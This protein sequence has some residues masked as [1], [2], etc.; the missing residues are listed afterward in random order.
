LS[1]E[2][3]RLKADGKIVALDETIDGLSSNCSYSQSVLLSSWANSSLH[4]LLRLPYSHMP[5]RTDVSITRTTSIPIKKFNDD[6]LPP[7]AVESL[8]VNVEKFDNDEV[9]TLVVV[10]IEADERDRVEVVTL[11]VCK[12]LG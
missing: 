8:V 5:V 11:D 4:L 2:V 9:I 12:L 1:S 10:N 3:V 7:L 6:E